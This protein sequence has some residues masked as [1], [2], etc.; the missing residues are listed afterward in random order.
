MIVKWEKFMPYITPSAA[1]C[2]A[3]LVAFA[4]I[5]RCREFC[6]RTQVWRADFEDEVTAEAEALYQLSLAGEVE[7]ILWIRLDGAEID[8]VD[9]RNVDPQYFVE[10]G[11]PIAYSREGDSQLRFYPIPDAAYA[12]VGRA[13]LKPTEA[14]F[15]VEEFIYKAHARTIASGALA[16]LCS[17]PGKPWSDI[18]LAAVHEQLFERGIARARVRDFRNVPLRVKPQFF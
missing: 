7:S 6:E 3:S 5:E 13:V 11:R 15:G 14:S 4:L 12:F 16:Q 10:S 17:I 1:S 18:N 2:P 8:P 9:D